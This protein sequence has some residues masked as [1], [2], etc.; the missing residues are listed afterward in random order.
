[1]LD[2]LDTFGCETIS[3]VAFLCR[4]NSNTSQKSIS[5]IYRECELIPT[6]HTTTSQ[7]PSHGVSPTHCG[8]PHMR[9]C[10]EVVVPVLYIFHFS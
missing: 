6:L 4:K 3:L 10:C 8:P 1:M 5:N 7:H 2:I 9:G